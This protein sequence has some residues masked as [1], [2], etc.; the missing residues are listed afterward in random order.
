M[1]QILSALLFAV[2]SLSAQVVIDSVPCVI[3]DS[4]QTYVLEQ[5]LVLEGQGPAIVL[6]ATDVTIDFQG[7]QLIIPDGQVGIALERCLDCTIT[8]GAIVATTLADTDESQA[9]TL[10]DFEGVTIENML[11]KDTCSDSS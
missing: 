1:K 11:F 10:Q 5:D 2:S 8:N 6:Q 3:T 9:I 7:Y 4:Q